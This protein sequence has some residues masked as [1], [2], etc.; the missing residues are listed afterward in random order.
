M[1][2]YKQVRIKTPKK[3]AIL[4]KLNKLNVSIKNITYTK[5]YLVFDILASDI[6]RVQKYLVSVKLE[7]ISDTGIYKVAKNLRGHLLILIG[8]IFSIVIFLVLTNIIVEVNVIHS[9]SKIRNLLIDAL[10][11]RGVTPLTFKKSYA[12]YEAIIADLKNTYKDEIEWLEI[13]VD[14]MVINVRVEERIQ[15]EFET[16]YNNCHIV[17]SKSGIIKSIL[18]EKGIAEVKTN[19]YVAKDEILISGEI[20]LID[21]IKNNVCAKGKVYAYV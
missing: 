19:D 8:V 10:A 7:I 18:T 5:D 9:N 4:L 12:E 2:H 17:A 14:G 16:E 11:E 13:D 3:S 20:K 6:K 15:K 21:V 1:N